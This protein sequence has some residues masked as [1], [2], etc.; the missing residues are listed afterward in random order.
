[1]FERGRQNSGKEEG[2]SNVR[3]TKFWSK[4][5]FNSKQIFSRP[6]VRCDAMMSCFVLALC[7]EIAGRGRWWGRRNGGKNTHNDFRCK[8]ECMWIGVFADEWNEI[9]ETTIDFSGKHARPVGSILWYVVRFHALARVA[10]IT[11]I[12]L[13]KRLE[14]FHSVLGCTLNCELYWV[15]VNFPLKWTQQESER[16]RLRSVERLIRSQQ[17]MRTNRMANNKRAFFAV[18]LT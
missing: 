2:T 16:A 7:M 12:D 18:P 14:L 1:M 11:R 5:I 10:G 13:Q 4:A 17:I 6:F 9:C 15:V 3:W 8:I